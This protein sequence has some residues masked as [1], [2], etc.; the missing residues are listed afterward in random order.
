MKVKAIKLG[1]YDNL[2]RREGVIFDIK[3]ESHFSKKWME[4][5]DIPSQGEPVLTVN[6]EDEEGIPKQ[7]GNPNWRKK[8]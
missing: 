8:E 6:M 3:D 5:V 1:F 4:R 7:R 2:R